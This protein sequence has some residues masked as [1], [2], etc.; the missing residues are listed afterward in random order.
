VVSHPLN[1]A[2]RNNL[3][4]I[5]NHLAE[6]G[7]KLKQHPG[8]GI[9]IAGKSKQSLSLMDDNVISEYQV[10]VYHINLG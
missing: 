5:N 8:L 3:T 9:S 7:S 2:V 1:E 6:Q 4:V 10:L